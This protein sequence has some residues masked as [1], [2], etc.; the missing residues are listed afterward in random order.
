LLWGAFGVGGL[1]A[2]FATLGAAG[3]SRLGPVFGVGVAM[4]GIPLVVCGLLPRSIAAV[5]AFTVI[6]AA[7]ALVDVS[8]FTLL[9]R[10]VP[11]RML[12]RVLAL[13]EAVFALAMALGSLSAAPLDA[14]L[15][16]AG[17]LVATGCLLPAAVAV[18]YVLLRDIDRHIG[19]STERIALLR[20]VGLLRLL[21]VPAIEGLARGVTSVHLPAGIDVFA[22]GDIGDAFYVVEA[23][24]VAV[25]D[26]ARRIRELG[27]GE[28]FGEIALMRSAPRTLTVRAVED[29]QLA[30]V[31]G[32]LFV[33]AVTGFS[34]TAAGA[35]EIVD[36]HLADDARRGTDGGPR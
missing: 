23:G 17:V 36:R 1:V 13:A 6:G 32:P 31:S 15:G 34:T 33:A 22:Q 10:V 12:A 29:V 18:S 20:K 11:D 25:L 26:G 5:A 27:P 14:A 9:Q 28:S 24:R 4:W 19:V 35:E 8:G 7:N 21:P 16:H 3:S 2:A 30:A